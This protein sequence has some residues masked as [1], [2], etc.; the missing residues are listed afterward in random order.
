MPVMRVMGVTVRSS[1]SK[2]SALPG[3]RSPPSDL[4]RFPPDV[5]FKET[6]RLP[7]VGAVMLSMFTIAIGKATIVSTAMPQ[8]VGQLGGLTLYSWVFSA[9]LLTQTAATV[10]FGKLSDVFGRRPTLLAGIALFLAGSLACGFAWSMEVLIV[11]RLLQGIGAGA[12][13]PI[14]QTIIGDLYSAEER[15]RVQG[16]LASVWAISAVLGPLV[17]ALIVQ[18]V[19]WSWIF[20]A[21]IPFGI[22]ACAGFVLF[23]HEG[24]KREGRKVDI[25]GAALFTLCIGALMI[26]LTEVSAGGGETWAASAAAIF[27]VAAA[28]FVWQERRAHEPIISFELWARRPIATADLAALLAGMALIG[29]DLP[30][31]VCAGRVAAVARR[32]GPRADRRHFRVALRRDARGAALRFYGLRRVMIGGSLLL[33]LGAT[34]FLVLG[35]DTSPI[36]AG[37]GSYVMGL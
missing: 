32:R 20:W 4:P 13:Q 6:R 25:A 14:A 22:L 16:A 28:A 9:F 26:A 10:V 11:F 27:V 3:G 17:G 15:G 21:N 8:I 35:P 31:H 30:A 12:I 18:H 5:R 23:L 33:P 2:P 1:A 24:V 34:A 37:L 29:L 36:V 7:V 19:S